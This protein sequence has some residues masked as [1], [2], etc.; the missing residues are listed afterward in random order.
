MNKITVIGSFILAGIVGVIFSISAKANTVDVITGGWSYH[1]DRKANYNEIHNSFGVKINDYYVLRYRNS[2]RD[3][4][5]SLGKYYYWSLSD[6]IEV[7]G[8]V[9]ATSGYSSNGLIPAILP[10]FSL[11]TKSFATDIIVIPSV[12]T[13]AHFRFKD[14]F[15]YEGKLLSTPIKNRDNAI[16]YSFGTLGSSVGYLGNINN[17]LDFRVE[18]TKGRFDKDKED[19]FWNL[20]LDEWVDAETYGAYLSYYPFDIKI[21]D[22]LAIEVGLIHNKSDYNASL[23]FMNEQ[24]NVIK[25]GNYSWDTFSEYVGLRYGRPWNKSLGGYL[26]IGVHGLHG[27]KEKVSGYSGLGVSD[28]DIESY[29]WYPVIQIG[30]THTF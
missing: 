11:Q 22:H 17:S 26:Q 27:G 1:S 4:S 29:K 23:T 2:N 25:R 3:E 13:Y 30:L 7:G 12:V 18:A 5:I 19:E 16:Y 15:Q 6:N 8:L 9:S 28:V 10:A 20:R 14:V 24:D 21:L